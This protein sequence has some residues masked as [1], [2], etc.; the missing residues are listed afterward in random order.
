MARL[1]DSSVFIELERRRQSIH[2]LDTI[3]H[4]EPIA[5]ASITVSEL[6]VGAYR[7]EEGRHQERQLAFVEALLREVPVLAFD[8]DTARAHAQLVAG[9]AAIGRPIGANDLLIAA[10][11]LTRGYSVLTHN[12]RHFERVPGL[13]VHPADL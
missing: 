10:T 1:I 11:A 8:L 4:G 2:V 12:V 3:L 7:S 6:L 9:L 5:L 13:I